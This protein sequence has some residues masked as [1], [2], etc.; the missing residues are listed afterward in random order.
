MSQAEVI[1]C[2]SQEKVRYVDGAL[3]KGYQ[4]NT[5]NS[6]TLNEDLP[7]IEVE[8]SELGWDFLHAF[9]QCTRP[10]ALDLLLHAAYTDQTLALWQV[11]G[12]LTRTAR[13]AAS[14]TA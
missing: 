6:R 3:Y 14:T 11:K 8:V 4:T 2:F 9:G 12:V 13:T 1:E 7:W 10:L 5:D